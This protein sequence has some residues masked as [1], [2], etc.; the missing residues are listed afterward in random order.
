[1]TLFTTDDCVL[2]AQLKKQFDLSAMDVQVEVLG[3]NDAGALAHLA[4]HGLVERARKGLPILVL[5]D[6]S[7]LHEFGHIKSQLLD[8]A[9]RYGCGVAARHAGKQA[10]CESG[11]CALQ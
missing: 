8:R 7:A 3:K 5:D 11:S 10:D 6:S 1:M 4:W 9:A 2:C